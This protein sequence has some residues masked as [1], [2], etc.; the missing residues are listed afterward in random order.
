MG[1]KTPSRGSGFPKTDGIEM[2]FKLLPSCKK[3]F[4]FISKSLWLDRLP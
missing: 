1:R 4:M 2:M 3:G